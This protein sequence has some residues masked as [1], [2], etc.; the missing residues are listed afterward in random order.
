LQE[1]MPSQKS[2]ETKGGGSETSWLAMEQAVKKER[3]E[4]VDFG[5]VIMGVKHMDYISYG[6]NGVE[7]EDK[8]T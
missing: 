5:A 3:T 6:I 1:G 7:K 8:S 4:E 2:E